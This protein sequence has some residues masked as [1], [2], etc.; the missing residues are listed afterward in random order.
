[1]E[2]VPSATFST[3]WLQNMPCD[4]TQRSWMEVFLS[5]MLMRWFVDKCD[6]SSWPCATFD[7]LIDRYRFPFVITIMLIC[8]PQ[9]AKQFNSPHSITTKRPWLLPSSRILPL[10]PQCSRDIQ[11]SISVISS[12]HHYN[13]A[14][15]SESTSVHWL[16]G[17]WRRIS[18]LVV[19]LW[20][21]IHK[22]SDSSHHESPQVCIP[23]PIH[24]WSQCSPIPQCLRG[25]GMASPFSQFHFWNKW[26]SNLWFP[27]S[28][29]QTGNDR[30]WPVQSA[31][32]RWG[33]S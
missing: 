25:H 13:L 19:L 17:W 30:G 12:S 7:C 2:A 11:G 21:F 22:I 20:F 27:S 6:T 18:K 33:R 1:M 15:W 32:D 23:S 8:F 9:R 5:T 31:I 10:G 28:T 3:F 4:C 29:H 14:L 26:R 24:T 16:W